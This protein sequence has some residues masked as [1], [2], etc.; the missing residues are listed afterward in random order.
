MANRKLSHLERFRQ[1]LDTLKTGL[2]PYVESRMRERFGDG[3]KEHYAQQD[4]AEDP[5]H[6]DVQVLLNTMLNHWDEIFGTEL[7][8][9]L[10]DNIHQVRKARNRFAHQEDLDYD[11]SYS[12]LLDMEKILK[13]INSTES[14]MIANL[15]NEMLRLKFEQSKLIGTASLAVLSPDGNE[16]DAFELDPPTTIGRSDPNK[17]PVDVDLA[18]FDPAGYISRRHAR[19]VIEG[20]DFVLQDLVSQNGTYIKRG[21][22]FQRIQEVQLEDGDEIGFGNTCCRFKLAQD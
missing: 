21:G 22:T 18:P 11:D 19:I 14:A 6:R 2:E 17:E 7:N 5:E 13:A 20:H 12:A 15:K 10:R 9:G 16:A 1:S 3:F 8:S 4:R